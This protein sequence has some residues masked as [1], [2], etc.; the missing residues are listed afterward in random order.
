MGLFKSKKGS[1][2]SEIFVVQEDVGKLTKGMAVEVALH[3]DHLELTAPLFVKTPIS[4]QYAQITDVFYG[5]QSEIVEKNK[6]TIG[7]AVAG[8]LLFGGAGAVVGAISGSGTKKKTVN[9]FMFIISYTSSA[10]ADAFLTFEDTRMFKGRKLAK[11][12]RELCGMSPQAGDDK[13]ITSL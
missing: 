2:I 3:D 1:I 11:Q 8:G 7:R 5:M 4:L 12:L 10:G 9:K 6:S 13:N